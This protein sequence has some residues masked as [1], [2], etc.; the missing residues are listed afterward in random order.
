LF[1]AIISS[2]KEER[3]LK[4]IIMYEENVPI[5]PVPTA[6]LLPKS[7]E[8]L[9]FWSV[10]ILVF[11]LPLFFIPSASINILVAK[12]SLL[13]GGVIVSMI[14]LLIGILRDG[15]VSFPRT[16][17]MWF[18]VLAPLVYLAAS[19]SSISRNLSF[20][21]YTLEV[22]TF[23]SML[24]LFVLLGLVVMVLNSRS[25][26][27]KMYGGMFAA[28]LI[29]GVFA[30]IKLFSGGN[31]LVLSNF[32]GNLGNPIGS[33][34]DY[35]IYFALFAV[36]SVAA[37]EWLGIK[38]P[39]RF[40]LYITLVLS[41]FMLAVINF[42]IAW[43]LALAGAVC[44]LIQ[45]VYQSMKTGGG[46]NDT[47]RSLFNAKYS[48]GLTVVSLFFVLNPTISGTQ[49][50][51][52]SL[53]NMFGIQNSEVRPSWGATLDVTK[54]I[55]KS[56]AILG[57]GPNTFGSEWLL[58]KPAVINGTA[59]WNV[60]FPFGIGFIPTQLASTGIIGALLWVVFFI[61]ILSLGVRYLW[62]RTLADSD[63]FITIGSY[64]ATLL[65]WAAS[66]LYVPSLVILAL[67]FIFTGMF[68][69]SLVVSGAVG[70]RT[71]T[72]AGSPKKNL[73]AVFV[74]ILLLLGVTTFG[75]KVFQKTMSVVYFQKALLA[76]NIS[77]TTP[78]ALKEQVTK[79]IRFSP[80]DLY[81][82]ALS[83]LAFNQAQ[84]LANSPKPE[85]DTLQKFEA[86]Y[87]EAVD[88][89][90]KAK[91]LNPGNYENWVNLGGLY[92]ALVPPP[93][94]VPGSYEN[95][96]KA[97]EEARV[98]NPRSPEIPLI[99]ARLEVA[100]NNI[101]SARSYVNEAIA[102]KN[103]YAA[104]YFLLARLEISANNMEPAIKAAE[105][106][107]V[108]SPGNAGVY[109]ELGLL[110]YTNKDY[111]GAAEAFAAALSVVPDY[112]NAQYFLGLS[113]YELGFKTEAL[114]QFQ[115]LKKTNPD[116]AEVAQIVANL[117]ADKAP[118]FPTVNKKVGPA[119]ET[120]P[121]LESAPKR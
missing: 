74:V 61:L 70:S 11:L 12:N 104:A 105:A 83:T 46:E 1:S 107:A 116:N 4:L 62:K 21:G 36:L 19:Y 92:E 91:D 66:I 121:P 111:R 88:N 50:I 5:N 80:Q 90:N 24:L 2:L 39:L 18:V 47:K 9:S 109:F 115:A 52:N 72:L 106:G 35:S 110:K 38:R 89:A 93:L 108:L 48:I 96:K 23:A 8:K 54:P 29:V 26:I 13:A 40:A 101:G 78:E 84:Q 55:L 120:N 73:V 3:T 75:F 71:I 45:S 32:S 99:Q 87:G 64:L 67:A 79:A 65:L 60:A 63:R 81:Y 119:S 94:S 102:L 42:S 53:S 77:E 113:L 37:L 98:R 7:Q 17:L 6:P 41:V 49:S 27:F 100:N 51:G 117:E 15:K 118:F 85:A 25:R 10:L 82:R 59:F 103:D 97:Y 114:Q 76:A 58:N 30:L 43:I 20:F 33:W 16:Y 34:T 22:G 112:A 95:A 69:A 28:F 86:A 44:I 56:D 68:I 57:A 14:F 31:V